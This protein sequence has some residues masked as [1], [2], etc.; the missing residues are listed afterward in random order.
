MKVINHSLVLSPPTADTKKKW[1]D[2]LLFVISTVTTLSRPKHLSD[3]FVSITNSTEDRTYSTLTA[4]VQ[5]ELLMEGFSVIE[6]LT[7]SLRKCVNAWTSNQAIWRLNTHDITEKLGNNVQLWQ[8]LLVSLMNS[9][10]DLENESTDRLIGCV[11]VSLEE[12]Q[13]SLLSRYD[14]LHKELL[15]CFCLSCSRTIHCFHSTT[16]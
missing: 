14:A 12:M 1:I 4:Q 3:L 10:A 2:S 13:S 15:G 11:R 9:K 8:T 5:R 16:S 7:G 6:Q